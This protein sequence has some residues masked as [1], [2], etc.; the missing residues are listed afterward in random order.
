MA[1]KTKDQLR[2]VNEANFPNNNTGFITP[3]RTREFN[4]DMIE[5]LALEADLDI[6]DDRITA[7]SESIEILSQSFLDYSS[8]LDD[9]FVS[10]AE[11][12]PYTASVTADSASFSN[13]V[14]DLEDFSSSLDNNFVSETEFAAYTSSNDNRVDVL[15]TSEAA[16]NTYTGS[17]DSRVQ[18]LE[19]ETGSLQAQIDALTTGSGIEVE[20]DGTNIGT[21]FTLNF[22]GDSIEATYAGT[23]ATI[24]VDGLA[25]TSSVDDLTEKTGSYATTGSNTFEGNQIVR[26]D[27]FVDGDLTARTLYID[28]SSI[29]YTSGSNKFGDSLDDVQELTGSVSITGSF[30]APLTEDYLWIGDSNGNGVEIPSA[31][32]KGVQFPFSGSAQITG[33]LGVTGSITIDNEGLTGSVIDNT[34][35]TY[36]SADKV[37]HVIS[38][39]QAE[40]DAIPSKDLNTLYLIS[41]SD[42]GIVSA[43]YAVSASHA[44]SSDFATNAGTASY[45]LGTNVDGAVALADLATT[46]SYILGSNVDGQVSDSFSSVS[47]SYAVSSSHSERS[48]TADIADVASFVSGANVEGAVDLAFTASYVA[49]ANVDG[50]VANATSSSHAISSDTAISSSHALRADHADNSTEIFVTAKNVSGDTIPKGTAV[51]STGVTGE[52]VNIVTASYND[53]NLMPAIGITQTDIN[54]NGNGEVILTGRLIGFDTTGLV[55]GNNVYVNGDGALTATRPTGSSLVQNIGIA[56]KIDATDG[57]VIVLGSGRSNDVPNILEGYAWV[58]DSDGVAQP[59]ATS[60]FAGGGSGEGFPFSGSAQ[61]TGSLGVTGSMKIND[62]TNSGN[63]VS[64][65][66]DTYTSVANI[67]FITT[68][69]QTEFDAIGTPDENTLYII[70]GSEVIDSTFPFSGS[71]QI[72]GSL[73]VTGSIT[74][75]DG[76]DTGSVVDNIGG[77][78]IPA[79]EHIV[80][81]DSASY[82]A[83][84]TYDENTLYVVSGSDAATLSPYTGSIRGNV[85]EVAEVAGDVALDFSLG[86]FFSSSIDGATNFVVSNV[87]PGQTVLLKVNTTQAAAV[88]TFSSNVKQ[89]VG[90]EYTAS[91]GN[92]EVD[93]L[94]FTSFDGTNANL[95]AVNNLK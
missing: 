66:K 39:S 17:N 50:T 77:N 82:A 83:L 49:G 80:S 69:T 95:V 31:S 30:S 23:T 56:A 55:A 93:I 86:N 84:G 13:R 2:Q 29:L 71:A 21:A 91:A 53:A 59:V 87:Q 41:G 47:A 65:V 15:E 92:N 60:S 44:D 94:T 67:D 57:E 20:N 19:T 85:T 16:L 35:D 68:L 34:T 70:S 46:S 52:N 38:L 72:T 63:V 24:T 5:S 10:E 64:N 36:A 22:E 1:E 9:D 90:N 73:G 45:I 6:A 11:F 7:N 37:E 42:T 27:L 48:D 14:T 26:G 3:A 61:I 78:T 51:H 89:P 58:G 4:D 33:S 81:I 74:I 28:S 40:Y 75:D 54:S 25:T 62:G 76:A 18:S 43:S 32:I 88:A 79:V 8:S 12:G